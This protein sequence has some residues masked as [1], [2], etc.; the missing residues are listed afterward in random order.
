VRIWT[1]LRA[2]A[3]MGAASFISMG[4]MRQDRAGRWGT[5][6]IDGSESA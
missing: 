1:G 4:K 3:R 6:P 2:Y 5:I